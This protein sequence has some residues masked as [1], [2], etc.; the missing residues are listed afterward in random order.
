MK[1]LDHDGLTTKGIRYSKPQIWRKVRDKTFPAPIKIGAARN[2]WVEAE[3]DEWIAE[4]I[5]ERDRGAS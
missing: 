1:L 4:R 2:A 5:A 3:I